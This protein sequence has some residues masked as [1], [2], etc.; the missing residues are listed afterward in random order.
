MKGIRATAIRMMP[1]FPED[2]RY[3][4]ESARA[5]AAERNQDKVHEIIDDLLRRFAHNTDVLLAI[6]NFWRDTQPLHEAQAE[7]AKLAAAS[8]PRVRTALA[9][10]LIDMG[11][12]DD[13]L[14]LLGSLAP[15]KVTGANIDSQTHYAR[16]LFVSG[17]TAKAKAKVDSVLA[18]DGANPEALLL[19][20]RLKLQ[21]RD[22][23]G[24]FTDAQLVTNDD[25]RNEEA[26]L[27]VAE[28]Y[29]AQGNP[30][31][32]GGAYGTARQQ[33]PDSTVALQAEINWL[34]S[35]KR[36]EEAAQRAAAF[37]HSHMRNGMAAKIYR[38]T[39]AKTHAGACGVGVS[40]VA[41]MLG[42]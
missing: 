3:A 29:T 1:L 17:Q 18:F 21:A 34:L 30:V 38:D 24:A 11:D 22:Y 16:A 42:M 15:A 36:T 32:A 4:L 8:P 20:A 10:Q 39:C 19:R 33:F 9:D 25:D 35:Q 6:G 26:A 40:N 7:I 27:L 12:P 31:L 37:Y 28:I 14:A 13:A 2:P 41:K 23:R 5:Y